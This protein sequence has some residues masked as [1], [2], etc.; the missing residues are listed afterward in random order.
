VVL[1]RV[2]DPIPGMSD[3][4]EVLVL[5]QRTVQPNVI[6]QGGCVP[7]QPIEG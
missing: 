1:V 2:E 3:G 4:Q 5:G 7:L 6:L